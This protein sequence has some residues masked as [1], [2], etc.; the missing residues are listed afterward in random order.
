MLEFSKTNS[1]FLG[2]AFYLITLQF[3]SVAKF[4]TTL[5]FSTIL[6]NLL[7]K[8]IDSTQSQLKSNLKNALLAYQ[9]KTLKMLLIVKIFFSDISPIISKVS[10]VN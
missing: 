5:S 9:K 2:L 8:I 4:L 10:F 6:A 1:T 7:L 3:R